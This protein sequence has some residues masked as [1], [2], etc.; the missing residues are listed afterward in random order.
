MS[1]RLLRLALCA[2]LLGAGAAHGG[3]LKPWTGGPAPPLSLRDSAGK[4]H[5][6]AAYRGK[7][8]LVNFWATWCA[9][10]RAEM[11]SMQALRARLAGKPFEVLAVNLM[12]SEEKIATNI[13]ANRLSVLEKSGLISKIADP[14]AAACSRLQMISRNTS[15]PNSGRNPTSG[16]NSSEFAAEK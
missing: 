8:V 2:V 16:P 1:I 14:I 9:P 12:E 15:V 7:V 13:L 5:D 11:P 10:C 4:I 3:E 6:L